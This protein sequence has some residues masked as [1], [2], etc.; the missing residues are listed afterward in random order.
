MTNK[1]FIINEK[2]LLVFIRFNSIYEKY[3][4]ETNV[5]AVQFVPEN[6]KDAL[7]EYYTKKIS[8]EKGKSRKKG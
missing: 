6:N 7:I 1:D 2:E 4:A 3:I 5:E 8:K